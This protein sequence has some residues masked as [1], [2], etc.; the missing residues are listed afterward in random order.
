[1]ALRTLRE[2]IPCFRTRS[3]YTTL[4]RTRFAILAKT[5]DSLANAKRNRDR[6]GGG[7]LETLAK[8][9]TIQEHHRRLE[10]RK[11]PRDW[12]AHTTDVSDGGRPP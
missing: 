8:E 2:K 7:R 5:E 1:M 12:K 6:E 9:L 3:R 4:S 11:A 10:Q